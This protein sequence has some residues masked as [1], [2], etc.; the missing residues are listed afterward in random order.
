[1]RWTFACLSNDARLFCRTS[2]TSF[3]TGRWCDCHDSFRQSGKEKVASDHATKRRL[4][5]DD[6]H[7]EERI[8]LEEIDVDD[9][10]WG[11]IKR[12][13]DYGC[14][15]ELGAQVDGFL[16]FMDHPLFGTN[17]GAPPSEFMN[18]SDRIRVWVA[19]VDM[20]K[21]RIKLT[22]IRPTHLPGPRRDIY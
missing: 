12:V 6:E 18:T 13:T 5:K 7:D 3:I 14:Y 20:D 15:V 8:P 21:K 16:H 9:E 17:N 2:S 1:M 11:E 4:G 22:A 19:D 10:L